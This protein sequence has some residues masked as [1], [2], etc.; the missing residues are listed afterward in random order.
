[1]RNKLFSLT[2]LV[3][4]VLGTG[5]FVLPQKPESAMEKRT[6]SRNDSITFNNR[7]ASTAESV[8]KDQF[9]FRDVL[10][11]EYYEMRIVLNKII[12]RIAKP[13][14]VLDNS[15]ESLQKIELTYLSDNVID[16]GNGYLINKIVEYTD[17]ERALAQ[18]RGYNVN[19][20]DL[21]Y[22]DVRTYVYFPTRLEEL[23]NKDVGFKSPCREDYIR[24][25]NEEI[26]YSALDIMSLEDHERYYYKSDEHW[27]SAGAYQAYRDIIA[28][29]GADF[30]IDPARE[31]AEETTFPFEFYGDIASQVG[32]YGETD[33]ITDYVL[34]GMGPFDYRENGEL[35]DF[36]HNQDIYAEKGNSTSYSDY[37]YYYG[38]YSFIREFDFHQEDR[39][40]LLIFSDSYISANMSWIASHFNKTVIIDLR[41]RDEEFSLDYY[42]NKY[43]FDIA[44]ILYS[45]NTMYFN[46][47]LFIPLND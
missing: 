5:L 30:E 21:K 20:F 44:L 35:A 33:R 38:H 25:L 12:N 19:D 29:I 4:L 23:L 45:Y 34:E 1:M 47:N 11:H 2:L 40:N 26:S 10:T 32:K 36:F 39:P 3:L 8:M 46:G 37:D 13:L 41:A 9:Y 22:P 14:M 28:M 31:I 43:D 17:E 15:T 7:F 42:M 16:T 27:N 24:Q 18:D 6:L